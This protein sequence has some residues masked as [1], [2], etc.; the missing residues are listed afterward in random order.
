MEKKILITGGLGFIG[1]NFIQL[2]F[3]RY[4]NNIQI[5]N[6]DKDTL[7]REDHRHL[8]HIQ[9]IHNPKTYLHRK[10]DICD[11]SKIQALVY[12]HRPD[13][14]VHFAAQSHVDRSI[15]TPDQHARTNIM[16]TTS[17]LIAASKYYNVLL[18][19]QQKKEFRFHHISTDEVFGD[20]PLNGTQKFNRNTL[21]NPSSPYSASKAG[22]DHLVRAWSRTYNLPYSISNCSN[23]YGKYQDDTK[24]IP[25]IINQCLNDQ[26][27]TV[28]GTGQYIRDWI[29][30]LDHC[31]GI[32][33]ILNNL[34]I[35]HNK[36]FLF[37][38]QRELMNIDLIRNICKIFD[39][40][41]PLKDGRKYQQNIRFVQNRKGQDL[42]YS[43]NITQTTEQLGWI[44][45]R[46]IQNELQN[47][48]DEYI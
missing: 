41:I 32:L 36:T 23:N 46:H 42:K 38:G 11:C 16:G 28:H 30:V 18:N 7:G 21:Y 40:K 26:I 12:L 10:V 27:I 34:Q 44:P 1:S 2:L 43:V 47:L 22:A 29:H 24:L 19:Q 35:S 14:I 6:I 8:Q 13:K 9:Q 4:G 39:E 17:M 31:E 20:L 3:S 25:I 5:I 48:I 15:Q 45:K 33:T 37:G